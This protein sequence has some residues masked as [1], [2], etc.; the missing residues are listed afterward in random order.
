MIQI[1]YQMGLNHQLVALFLKLLEYLNSTTS[2][3]LLWIKI[4]GFRLCSESSDR[5]ILVLTKNISPHPII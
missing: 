4:K 2:T 5:H 3:R 1:D